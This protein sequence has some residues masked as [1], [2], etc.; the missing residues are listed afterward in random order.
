MEKKVKVKRKRES[1][2]HIGNGTLQYKKVFYT[3]KGVVE[4]TF[5]FSLKQ[6]AQLLLGERETIDLVCNVKEYK[7]LA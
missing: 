4:E 3:D 7:G 5:D 6:L 2:K 1:V